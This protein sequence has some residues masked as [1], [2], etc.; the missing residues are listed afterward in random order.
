MVYRIVEMQD[1]IRIPPDMLGD[2][3]EHVMEELVHKS[4]EGKLSRLN[5]ITVLTQNVK[6]LGEGLMIHGD[7]DIYQKVKF[8]AL[9]FK[10]EIQEVVDGIVAEVA[11][12]GAFVHIGPLD[13]L[14]HMS[15]VMN[16]YVSVDTNNERLVGKESKKEVGVG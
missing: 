2:D 5:G 1:T 15:Q 12:F 14:V 9:V 8:E 4:F 3:L 16:D 6:P 10:P 7:G 13:A 11:E